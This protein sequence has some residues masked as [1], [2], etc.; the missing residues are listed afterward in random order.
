MYISP[1]V[2]KLEFAKLILESQ[3][4][5]FLI[6]ELNA[7]FHYRTSMTKQ[8]TLLLTA[9]ERARANR[10]VFI[11]CVRDY[12]KLDINY[13]NGKAQLL[14]YLFDV[15]R[16]FETLQ[17]MPDGNEFFAF[18][19]SYGSVFVGNSSLEAEDK[20]FFHFLRGLPMANMKA[21]AERLP[22]WV[23]N[24]IVFPYEKYGLKKK[25]IE[26]YEKMKRESLGVL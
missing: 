4:R 11:G 17:K 14:I 20:F 3:D 9:I 12:E 23:G 13:R 7:F 6:D 2:E 21:S 24:I 22:S 15:V 10:N 19:C 26:A 18:R 1:L 5:V 16:D 25:D 8:Q